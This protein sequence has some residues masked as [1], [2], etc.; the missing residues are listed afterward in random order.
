[1]SPN[2]VKDEA[3]HHSPLIFVVQSV[4]Q[5]DTCTEGVSTCPLVTLAAL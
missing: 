5:P 2:W 1:M 3:T 4:S